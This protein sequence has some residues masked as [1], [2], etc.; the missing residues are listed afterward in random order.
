M[1]PPSTESTPFATEKA[2]PPG[3]VVA[4]PQPFTSVVTRMKFAASPEQ[5]WQVLMFYEQ[6]EERPPLHLRLLLPLP[7]RTE[8]RKSEV[9]DEARCVYQGGHL[10]KRVTQVD[11]GCYYGFEVVEQHLRVGSGIRLLGGGYR[12]RELMGGRTEIA[13]ETRY[14]SPRR[15]HWLWK[16]IEAAVCHMFHRHILGAMR[17]N[18]GSR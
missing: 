9:A 2:Q 1:N 16:P 14:V 15:P 6:I 18:L 13:L 17:R 10:L 5:A 7:I 3:A 11:P 8:G 4:V 12:L